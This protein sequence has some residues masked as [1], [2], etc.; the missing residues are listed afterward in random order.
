[1][2]RLFEIL[3]EANLSINAKKTK[4]FKTKLTF[5]GYSLDSNGIQIKKDSIEAITNLAYPKCKREIRSFLGSMNYFNKHI[6]NLHSISAP[7]SKLTS[8]KRDFCFEEEQ[9]V[10]FNSLKQLLLEAPILGFPN[11]NE[12][13]FLNCDASGHA[14]GGCLAQNT[15]LSRL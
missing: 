11:F 5:L 15:H 6:K 9:K 14:V 2:L 7:L 3:N 12:K 10:A 1:M 13:F 4:L 8:S